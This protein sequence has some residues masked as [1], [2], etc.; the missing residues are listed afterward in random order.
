M[1]YSAERT[2][3]FTDVCPNVA[4]KNS[5]LDCPIDPR[6]RNPFTLAAGLGP[7]PVTA[8]AQALLP[9]IPVGTAD[10]PG[11]AVYNTNTT[12][13]TNWREELFR[14][15]HNITDHERA[16]FRYIHDSWTT[17]E[18]GP[19]WDT[20]NFPTSQTFFNGP[21]ISLV[22][23]LTST[24]SPTLLN[25]FVASYTTDHIAFKSVGYYALPSGFSM[26]YLY[27]NGAGG[28]LP[29]IYVGAGI[30]VYGGGFG[31]D[32]EGVWPEG[33]YN[34][35]PTYTYR[36]NMTKIMGR[37]NLTFGAYLV[38]AQKNELSSVQVNG[39]LTFSKAS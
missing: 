14:I 37:H 26:G 19:I 36:D 11:A 24:V 7:L 4:A 20:T 34:S 27:N 30:N 38:T 1:P 16:T 3:D 22:A 8:Q 2:G 33:P 13:P 25:E 29:A 15:D 28:K 6:T 17:L 23:R 18:P 31:Q 5:T 12:L 32:P 35:N 9:L 21:G 39:S 10:N